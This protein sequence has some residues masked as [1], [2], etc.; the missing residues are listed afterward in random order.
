MVAAIG[1]SMLRA[2]YYYGFGDPMT[3]LGYLRSLLAGD[4]DVFDLFYPVFH[5]FVAELVYLLGIGPRRALLLTSMVLLL[6]WFA[7]SVVLL[8]RL[9][10][11][12]EAG[13]VFLA[14][15]VVLPINPVSIFPRPHP[16][17]A[18]VFFT[19]A[20]LYAFVCRKDR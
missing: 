6:T 10:A 17:T 12:G 16:A 18:A 14:P 15:L 7:G 3:H 5:T 19:P 1:L 9:G 20:V 4:L 2:P 13:I 8:R 11:S